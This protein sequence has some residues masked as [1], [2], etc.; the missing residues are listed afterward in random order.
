MLIETDK[1]D[2]GNS[3][4]IFFKFNGIFSYEKYFINK[5]NKVFDTIKSGFS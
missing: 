5:K 2:G 3:K 4:T 1:T